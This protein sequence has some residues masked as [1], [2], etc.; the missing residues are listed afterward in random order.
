MRFISTPAGL[1]SPASISLRTTV[2]SLSRSALATL[3]L[4]MRSASSPSSQSSV[5]SLAGN[6]AK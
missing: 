5:S 4:T 6:E 3:E 1:L 2:I